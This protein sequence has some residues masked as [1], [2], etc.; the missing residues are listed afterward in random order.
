MAQQE[1]HVRTA[2]M[3]LF[4]KDFHCLAGDC[5]DNCCGGWEISFNKNDYLRVKRAAKSGELKDILSS[6]MSRL[7]HQRSG[8]AY[9]HFKTEAGD[10]CA[11]QTEEGLCRLQMEC[12][13]EAMPE[14]CRLYPRGYIYTPAAKEYALSPT[15]EGVLALLWDLPQGIDF[16]EEDL[17][18][19]EWRK[20]T[21]TVPTGY[22]PEIRSLWI[23]VLQDRSQTLP[24]RL[25]LLG[26]M[27]Q[28]L[29]EQDWN[30]KEVFASWLEWGEA[31]LGSQAGRADS[32][33]ASKDWSE[34]FR[35]NL[36][37]LMMLRGGQP[38]KTDV[39]Q[40]LL[41]SIAEENVDGKAPAEIS[42][43]MDR[44]RLMERQLDTLLGRSDYFF[45]NLL[46]AISFYLTFPHVVTPETLW[47]SYVTL[48]SLYSFYRFAA[49]YGCCLEAS[50]ERLFHVLVHT[51][52]C[53]LHNES[54]RNRL[55]DGLFKEGKATLAY[56]EILVGD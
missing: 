18:K 1:F 52:R 55:A 21:C 3:P 20:V 54:H 32:G 23:D 41:S 51:G 30:E 45:E 48:C 46:V 17:P 34:Y 24:Q 22:F 50:R 35:E 10:F 26:Q 29:R 11:F 42:I 36:R 25:I 16:L 8:D 56:M 47:K 12:G 53:L 5:R 15:C 39:F 37:V 13:A 28:K 7:R 33:R 38:G 40:E 31:L 27:I 49:V 6:G 44:Y 14:V 43:D 9:A 2:L 4:Y 19:Q